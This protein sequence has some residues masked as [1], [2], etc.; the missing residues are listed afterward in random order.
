MSKFKIVQLFLSLCVLCVLMPATSGAAEDYPS[1]TGPCDFEFP[2]DH[3]PHP[4]YRTEWWYYTGNVRDADGNP[5]GF[6]LTF[7]RSRIVPES[8]ARSWPKPASAWRTQQIYL[9]HAAVTDVKR[10]RHLQAESIA[11]GVL[12]IAG[13]RST[14]NGTTVFL[15]SWSAEITSTVHILKA[16]TNEFSIQLS[17]IP[18]KPVVAHGDGGYSRKG[19]AADRASCYYSIPRFAASGSLVLNEQ[20]IAVQG[21][22]WMDHEYSSAPLEEGIAGW[23]WFS[24][25]FSNNTELMVYFIRKEDGSYHPVS[26]GTFIESS[27]EIQHLTRNDLDL[28]ILDYWRSPVSG[29]NYPARWRLRVMPLEMDLI[30]S[31]RVPDQEMRTPKSTGVTY[32]EGS[33]SVN[34]TRGKR[35]VRGIGFVELTGY[36]KALDSRL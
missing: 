6:Q 7:F 30:L 31:P 32:W 12:G 2:R 14:I 19:S 33:I 11:R 9:A 5:F 17:L 21:S 22:S 3:G 20:S 18:A 34:G 27:G 23:D 29:G 16:E 36:V 4:G 25:Q 26:S 35:S 15:K 13:T 24:L 8:T 1:I 10:K 28:E